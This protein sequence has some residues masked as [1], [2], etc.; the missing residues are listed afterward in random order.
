MIL[1]LRPL[2]PILIFTIAVIG[3]NQKSAKA[4]SQTEITLAIDSPNLHFITAQSTPWL[5]QMSPSPQMTELSEEASDLETFLLRALQVANSLEDPYGQATLLN[6]IAIKYANLGKIARTREILDQSLAV[7]RTIEDISN[8]VTIMG[9]IAQHYASIGQLTTANT[10]LSETVEIANSVEDKSLQA[11][12]LSKIALKYADFAQQSQTETLLSQ[13]EK[14]LEQAL[15][16]VADFPFQPTPLKGRFTIGGEIFAG[17]NSKNKLTT[18]LKLGQQFAKKD[19]SVNID[20]DT[21][22]DS[23]RSKDKTRTTIFADGQY[24]RH[25]DQTW[26]LFTLA[27]F[28]RNIKD[29][30]F[31]D[32]EPLVGPAMNI[33]RQGLERSLDIGVGLGVR[34]Q[35]ATGKPNVFNLPTAGVV[36]QYS[37]LFF[38]SLEFEH[39]FFLSIPAQNSV[40]WRLSTTTEL[41]VPLWEKWFFTTEV[42]YIFRGIP[43]TNKPNSEFK[44]TTGVSYEF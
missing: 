31:Y 8:K 34:Y 16:P 14:I 37:D 20:Y 41:S 36:V 40:D 18:A 24:R 42:R 29:E 44:F 32:L 25:F 22:F 12:L 5:T 19:F 2:V 3:F 35:D 7:A 39:Q 1:T 11:G 10:I 9:A 21:N 4:H 26:Q 17:T 6:D 23:S 33:F 30:I 27:R 38:N 13:S 43:A 28:E 15:L